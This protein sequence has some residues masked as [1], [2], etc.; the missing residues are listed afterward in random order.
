MEQAPEDILISRVVGGEATNGDWDR[1][2]A[3]ADGDPALWRR[4]G[5]TL[6]DQ[7]GFARAVNASVSIAEAIDL[8][9]A[10][11]VRT[12]PGQAAAHVPA[13]RIGRWSGWAVAAVVA[14]AWVA[15]LFE[16]GRNPNPPAY[17]TA[18]LA[19]APAADLLQAYLDR[20]RREDRVIGEVPERVLIETRPAAVGEGYELLYLRQILERA[21]VPDL[22]HFE[23]RDE[24]GRPTLVRYEGKRQGPGM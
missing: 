10:P 12:T 5:E 2:T 16:A 4:L 8:P 23:G 15:W 22:Y 3:L 9:P 11:R 6:R 18:G 19:G 24:T 13:L 14:I 20:G 21:V 1:L 17:N 7:A